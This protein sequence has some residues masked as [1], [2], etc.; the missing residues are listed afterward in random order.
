MNAA[1][2]II[3]KKKGQTQLLEEVYR[4]DELEHSRFWVKFTVSLCLEKRRVT[5]EVDC[6]AAVTLVSEKMVAEGG[7]STF[8]VE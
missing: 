1:V 7:I 2:K 4:L 6:G 8:G 5:F 3:C